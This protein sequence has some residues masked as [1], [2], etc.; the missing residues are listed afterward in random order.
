MSFKG[1]V[2]TR[3]KKTPPILSAND[4]AG[5]NTFIFFPATKITIGLEN[6]LCLFFFL[7]DTY[8]P[9]ESLEMP[10]LRWMSR[11]CKSSLW[12][13]ATWPARHGHTLLWAC[14]SE[15][16]SALVHKVPRQ[17]GWAWCLCG[18]RMA[19]WAPLGAGV[20]HLWGQTAS[21]CP[22]QYCCIC[23]CVVT[24]RNQSGKLLGI[25]AVHFSSL[26]RSTEMLCRR[27]CWPIGG[28]SWKRTTS[29]V[30]PQYPGRTTA[31][32]SSAAWA[33]SAFLLPKFYLN[34]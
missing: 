12:L 11:T 4:F 5:I 26:Q 19:A 18:P 2:L 14:H 34:P 29:Q 25:E 10:V 22:S 15:H 6:S 20:H 23:F 16:L 17:A 9:V 27:S 24:T 8:T 3:A 32:A 28:Q 7:K 21:C 30:H 31:T 33:L 1:K 13:P